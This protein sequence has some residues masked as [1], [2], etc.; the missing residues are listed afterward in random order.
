VAP[1][2]YKSIIKEALMK[3]VSLPGYAL[4]ILSLLFFST[5]ALSA[6]NPVAYYSFNNSVNPGQDS[7][8]N[9]HNGTVNGATW[10]NDGILG[11][12][13]SF[14][15]SNYIQIPNHDSLN[16]GK[17]DFTLS[18]WINVG[19]NLQYNEIINKFNKNTDGDRGYILTL[20]QGKLAFYCASN[21]VTPGTGGII[22][23][24]SLN[25]SKWHHVAGVRNANQM[26]I[27][28][29][30]QYEASFDGAQD[31]VFS[32]NHPLYIGQ[33]RN[34]YNNNF[35][36]SGLIDEVSIYNR[37]LSAPEI[38]A[39]YSI[40]PAVSN[41]MWVN[42]HVLWF[43]YQQL[44]DNLSLLSD[45][46]INKLYVNVGEL[47]SDGSY[48][49]V[50][51]NGDT[52]TAC[53]T[54]FLTKAKQKNFI[55]YAYLNGSTT[56][57]Q[58]TPE[59][60]PLLLADGYEP[61]YL[62]ISKILITV[63]TILSISGFD[64]IHLDIEPIMSKNVSHYSLEYAIYY[65]HARFENFQQLLSDLHD[66]Y[67]DIKTISI[68]SPGWRKTGTG[69]LWGWEHGDYETV[70]KYVDHVAVMSYSH[71]SPYQ[72]YGTYIREAVSD[73]IGVADAL[74]PDTGAPKQVKKVSLG[75]SVERDKKDRKLISNFPIGLA[76]IYSPSS[77]Y[78]GISIFDFIN[79]TQCVLDYWLMY[80]YQVGPLPKFNCKMNVVTPGL[81]LLLGN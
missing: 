45:L 37:A 19:N 56:K 9:A 67:K 76:N 32:S 81:L 66:S 35:P 26:I 63:H 58:E 74:D 23:S 55:V 8:G 70:F 10:I 30:G 61:N 51:G 54:N 12:A 20:Y 1:L 73:I 72:D 65:P 77:K 22:G 53:F 34:G 64:G 38:T 75:L 62:T 16:F 52:N 4:L 28:I 39:L 46:Q 6:D 33:E 36:Y 44:E 42:P 24:K 43:D 18:A 78:D 80:V 15:G 79:S 3:K 68:A 21:T 2:F 50:C 71:V 60:E 27:Y 40:K 48:K 31:L 5:V 14:T 25:D 41:G 17:N 49:S 59:K 11:G 7:S 13:M 47:K 69:D 29:D 57:S